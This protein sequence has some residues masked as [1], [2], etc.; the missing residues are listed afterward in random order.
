MADTNGARFYSIHP[1][2]KPFEKLLW[3]YFS[4]ISGGRE[5]NRDLLCNRARDLYSSEE[6]KALKDANPLIKNELSYCHYLL[7][8]VTMGHKQNTAD[9]ILFKPESGPKV[10]LY[11]P[12]DVV[13]VRGSPSFVVPKLSPPSMSMLQQLL[14]AVMCIT[15]TNTLEEAE[16]FLKTLKENPRS[17][18]PLACNVSRLLVTKF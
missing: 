10:S 2:F 8:T 15:G 17:S 1:K 7:G 4:L 13:V 6:W 9:L 11:L 18:F 5:V 3:A 12:E 16:I 14:D